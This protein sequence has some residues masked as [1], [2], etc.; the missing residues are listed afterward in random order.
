MLVM[1]NVPSLRLNTGTSIPQVGL[2][3]FQ[4]PP[5]KTTA[6]VATSIE[7]GYRSIDTARAYH[8]EEQV[9]R[10]IADSGLGRDEIFVTTKLWNDAH[11]EDSARRAFDKSLERLGLDAVDLYL[12]HWP[13][14]SRNRY[15][16]TWKALEEVYDEGLA[17][18]IGVSNFQP[19]HLQRLLAECDV[20]P[21]VNQIELH[22]R[23]PQAELRAFHEAHGILTEAWSPLAQGELLDDAAIGGIAAAHGRTHAQV[24]L[25]WHVQLGNVAIPKSVTPGR[26]QTNIDVFDF[27]LSDK[28]MRSIGA[29]DAGADGRIGPY[30]DSFGN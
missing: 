30:P 7:R 2:G 3:V 26:I 12:V 18:A 6:A 20:V 17:R 14:P 23:F 10:A 9:G 13:V 8:N 21:A 4:I 28:Q 1:P 22:P 25:R 19:S 24:I 16:E 29:L 5:E 15:V 27:E 11:G